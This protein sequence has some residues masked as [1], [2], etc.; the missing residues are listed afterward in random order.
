MS[1]PTPLVVLPARLQNLDQGSRLEWLEADGRGGYAAS[2]AVGANTR[3][4]HGL[5]VV[6]RRPPT[7]RIVLLSRFEETLVTPAGEVVPLS[8]NFYPGAVHP[9]GHRY[10]EEFRLDPW[11]VWRYRIGPLTLTKAL[12]VSR[13]AGAT[14]I[15]YYL[16]GGDAVLELRPL[17]AGRDFHALVRANDAVARTAE[18]EHGRIVYRPYPDLPPIV[19]SHDGGEWHPGGEWYYQT[20][21]PRETER[22]L[23]DREDLFCPGVLRVPLARG[24][25]WRMACS[26][27][28]VPVHRAAEWAASER[29]RRSAAAERGRRAAGADVGLSELGARLGLA[30]EA[31][32]VQRD[33]G[34]SILAGYPWFADWGRDAMISIPGLCL[35][36]GRIEEAARVLDTFAAHLRDGLIPNRFPDHG[37]EVPDDHY[38]AADASLWFV[39]AVAALA[40]RGGDVRPF[41][42]AVREIIHAYQR[43]TRF[44]IRLDPDGLIRQGEAGIQLTWMDAKVDG[45]VITPRIGKAVEINALWFNAL[46]RAADLARVLGADPAPYQALAERARLGFRAFWYAERGYLYDVID[47]AG[48]PD[49]AL[50]PNQLLAIS[51]PYSP[52]DLEQARSIVDIVERELLVPLAVRTLPTSDPG[53][54]G[55]HRGAPH[56]RDAA[57]HCGTAWPWLLGPFAFAYLRVHGVSAETRARIRALLAPAEARMTEY[58]LGHI[59][60]VVDGDSPHEPSGC[61]AQ[62]W[63]CAE[64]L[65][66]LHLVGGEGWPPG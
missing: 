41:W 49:P 51:L 59:P 1:L 29:R 56:E 45:R 8:V 38:N 36:T 46:C 52:L 26:T 3:R 47:D 20:L 11:P 35:V 32:L 30:A 54:I 28:P 18:V 44:G 58:G 62:A 60:E 63:S 31:F 48:L 57:Y 15:L 10:L 21:Y 65:R 12:F 33:D 19:L 61:F 50:R 17:V 39:E 43:G 13:A 2:T 66:I 5:L 42:P 7:D 9:T 37:G 25:L 27:A 64:L 16:Q 24:R 40:E 53:Y 14:V 55:N 34:L 4:Y 23:D 6:A 22:G